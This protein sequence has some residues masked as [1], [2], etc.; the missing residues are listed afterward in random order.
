MF[1]RFISKHYRYA[2][3][4]LTSGAARV[5]VQNA[6]AL[7]DAGFLANSNIRIVNKHHRIEVYL[8]PN[9]KQKI[10]D[11]GRGELLEMKNK[12]TAKSLDGAQFVSI[13]FR[14]GKI[15]IQLHGIEQSMRERESLIIRRIRNG[16]PLRTSCFF[17]GL[18]LL[19]Y[20]IKEGLAK[21]GIKTEIAFAN[22]INEQA[23][24]CNLEG[25]PMWKNATED[26]SAVLDDLHALYRHH[27]P[28]SDIATIGYPCVG[29]S[30]LAKKE[31]RDLKHPEC[32]SLFIPLVHALRRS[33]PALI[34]IE[35]TPKF[36]TSET[37][38]LMQDS[39]RDY[40]FSVQILDGHDYNELDSRKRVCVVGISKGLTAID[41]SD[42]PS[43][44]Q[45]EPVRKVADILSAVPLNDDCWDTMDHV[46]A[47]DDMPEVGYRNALYFGHESSMTTI[48]A[49]YNRKAGTPMIAHPENAELQ[50]QVQPDEHGRLRRVPESLMAVVMN[51]WKG[52]HPL[53]TKRGSFLAAHRLLG[54]SVSRNVWQSLGAALGTQLNQQAL[55]A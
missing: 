20:H 37:L 6:Q 51:I 47:R 30:A 50:R 55:N 4:Y 12:A 54:N 33:N 5:Y 11:T 23:L 36:A 48:P 10:M 1:N 45:H 17:S 32:G 3:K 43:L 38:R 2:V 53:V 34:V 28:Q 13:T 35:N 40:T 7:Q 42:V 25:N 31:N 16:E 22:D 44:F 21:A 46:K 18:G 8:D 15:I 26:A 9:G 39:L 27:I 24:S 52:A 41:L 49:T 19:S 29:Q 14:Q